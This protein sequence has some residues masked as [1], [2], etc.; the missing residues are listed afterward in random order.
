[1]GKARR[2]STKPSYNIPLD[3]TADDVAAIL[4]KVPDTTRNLL[5]LEPN[6]RYSFVTR[7]LEVLPL[8]LRPFGP[9]VSTAGS[10]R[11]H[12]LSAMYNKVVRIIEK[13]KTG[14]PSAIVEQLSS[15]VNSVF[16]HLFKTLG[17]KQ[18]YIRSKILGRRV[19][20]CARAVIV[21]DPHHSVDSIGLPR[22]VRDFITK[23]YEIPLDYSRD[24]DD[25]ID[26]Y[27]EL[28]AVGLLHV[29]DGKTEV[30]SPKSYKFG[31][32]LHPGRR[33]LVPIAESDVVFVNRQPTLHK[34]NLMAF[35]TWFHDDQVI[36]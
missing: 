27:D 11:A 4:E 28:E 33:L 9:V 31:I 10:F 24:A 23:V 29:K 15:S 7:E 26:L 17:S 35:R 34:H 25:L 22:S 21:P 5:A 2:W 36:K 12:D 16:T 14:D 18:G 6:F 32:M 1:M 13:Q 8:P 3:L 19:N 30:I 20:N